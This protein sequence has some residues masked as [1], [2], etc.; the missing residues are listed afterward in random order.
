M[1]T[2]DKEL[3]GGKVFLFVQMRP[4]QL[5]QGGEQLDLYNGAEVAHLPAVGLLQSQ[6]ADLNSF[7][8]EAQQLLVVEVLAEDT[9]SLHLT[10]ERL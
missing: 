6:L 3:G 2:E 7:R 10:D 5:R 8:L 9:Q 1:A 4:D